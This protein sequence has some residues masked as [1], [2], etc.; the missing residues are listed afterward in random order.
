MSVAGFAGASASRQ[1][2]LLLALQARENGWTVVTRDSDLR[3]LRSHVK[4]LSVLL[5]YPDRD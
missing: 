2:D 1:N 3:A 5:P 4:G